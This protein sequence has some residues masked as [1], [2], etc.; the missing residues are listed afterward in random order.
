M[1]T[2]GATTARADHYAAERI[3]REYRYEIQKLERKYDYDRRDLI[4]WRE[5]QE[6]HIRRHYGHCGRLRAEK[7]RWLYREFDRRMDNLRHAYH[8]ARDYAHRRYKDRL[9][10]AHDSHRHK[11]PVVVRERH[12]H[13]YH[14][15]HGPGHRRGH[16]DFYIS[17]GGLRIGNP[18]KGASLWIKF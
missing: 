18:H 17:G 5:H 6:E 12:V 14:K 8:D 9:R 2:A 13:H 7:H 1:L 11:P 16:S 4:R 10:Y 3:R 15:G